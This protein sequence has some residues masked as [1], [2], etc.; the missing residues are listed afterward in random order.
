[1]Y[2]FLYVGCNS[3]SLLITYDVTIRRIAVER[4][5]CFGV[6]NDVSIRNFVF[7]FAQRQ[8][9]HSVSVQTII[10]NCSTIVEQHCSVFILFNSVQHVTWVQVNFV[11]CLLQDNGENI[12]YHFYTSAHFRSFGIMPFSVTIEDPSVCKLSRDLMGGGGEGKGPPGGF[13]SITQIRLGIAL[14][15]FQ[16]LSGHQFY[17]SSENFPRGH[18][19]SKVIE[20]K[21]R[22]C[23][24]VF[25]KKKL[26]QV[27][28]R[29]AVDL[30]DTNTKFEPQT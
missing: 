12:M 27:K 9:E 7:W 15:N 23:S 24:D 28:R 4:N 18:S 11:T 30:Q 8:T 20:V 6:N 16:C 22:S 3:R 2:A 1:M 5:L 29:R 13:S 25:V 19:R 10:Q 17:T 14:W 21:L 26:F